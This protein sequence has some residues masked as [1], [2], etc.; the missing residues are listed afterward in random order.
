MFFNELLVLLMA[1]HQYHFLLK[2]FDKHINL[3]EVFKPIY[4][5][6][7]TLMEDEMPNEVVR[8]GDELKVPVEEIL[9]KVEQMK[10]DYK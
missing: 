7:M 1:K 8:M 9:E 3:K 5:A 6:L 4:Y 2:Q 10:I